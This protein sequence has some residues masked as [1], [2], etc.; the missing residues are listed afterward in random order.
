MLAPKKASIFCLKIGID[1]FLGWDYCMG[2]IMDE[3]LLTHGG[4]GSKVGTTH[5]YLSGW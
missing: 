3:S 4:L 2:I 5:L 1:S